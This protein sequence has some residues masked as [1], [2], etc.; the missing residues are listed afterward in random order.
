MAYRN[1]K[2]SLKVWLTSVIV[3]PGLYTGIEAYIDSL[4][5]TYSQ[6]YFNL[7]IY[8]FMVRLEFILSFIIW[9]MFWAITEAIIYCNP[10]NDVKRWLIFIVAILLA[11]LPFI[12]LV[13]LPLLINPGS[14]MFIPMLA[15][16][17]CIGC[18][19]WMY[20]L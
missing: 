17:F 6:I 12:V 9:L 15:N 20:R 11:I 13:G 3:A 2:F 7:I 18:G 1:L 16:V 5:N 10:H 19:C 14:D 8:M 4:N